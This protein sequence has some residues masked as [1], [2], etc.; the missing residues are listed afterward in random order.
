M[1]NCRCLVGHVMW[2]VESLPVYGN[3]QLKSD[4]TMGPIKRMDFEYWGVM[5]WVDRF[6]EGEFG[7]LAS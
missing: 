6:E 4:S 1:K 5:W 3:C 7:V 2:G